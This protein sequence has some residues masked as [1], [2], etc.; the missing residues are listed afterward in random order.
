M[1]KGCLKRDNKTS[2]AE[3]NDF[4]PYEGIFQLAL[5]VGGIDLECDKESSNFLLDVQAITDVIQ[6]SMMYNQ[7]N[8]Q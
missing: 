5:L 7:Q 1:V 4:C 3:P 8:I 6:D 2:R